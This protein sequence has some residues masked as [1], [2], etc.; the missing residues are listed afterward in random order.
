MTQTTHQTGVP[1]VRVRA[2]DPERDPLGGDELPFHDEGAG[3]DPEADDEDQAD[4]TE[5][6]GEG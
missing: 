6:G 2:E 5:H 1:S 4:E 3:P